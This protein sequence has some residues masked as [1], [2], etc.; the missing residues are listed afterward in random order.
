L[1]GGTYDIII[2]IFKPKED[3]VMPATVIIRYFD[4]KQ[5]AEEFRKGRIRLCPLKNFWNVDNKNEGQKDILEGTAFTCA[6]NKAFLPP[7]LVQCILDDVVRYRY[8]AYQYYNLCCFFRVDFYDVS[9]KI[10]YPPESMQRE[11]G[12]YAV[13]VWQPELF[14]RKIISF[15][16]EQHWDCI[17]GDVNYYRFDWNPT[18][19]PHISFC[20]SEPLPEILVEDN[21]ELHT[22]DCFD[23]HRKYHQQREWRVCILRGERTADYCNF[24]L[25]DL[26]DFV[27][28]VPAEKVNSELHK[29]FS[30]YHFSCLK[31]PVST[32]HGNITRADLHKKTIS[33]DRRAYM[34]FNI[35]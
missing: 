28:V 35:G 31:P 25:G 22:F 11:F 17:C 29:V 14:I 30:D 9:R 32:Y 18:N 19:Q 26:S 6:K 23:K 33:I 8:V 16:N 3:V 7:N 21:T 5:Y 13:I 34:L 20:T 4:T 1:E 2:S 27:D 10:Y 24:K 12:D 15:A